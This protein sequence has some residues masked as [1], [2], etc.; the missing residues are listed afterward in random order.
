VT[1][2]SLRFT[3][4]RL[5]GDMPSTTT[6]YIC[7][8][9]T[10]S[11]SRSR[12]GHSDTTPPTKLQYEYGPLRAVIRNRHLNYFFE[13]EI[14]KRIYTAFRMN[15]YGSP[16]WMKPLQVAPQKRSGRTV[17]THIETINTGER[18][19]ISTVLRRV[20]QGVVRHVIRNCRASLSAT[21]GISIC[22]RR[23]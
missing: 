1:D 23:G 9:N 4:V 14:E 16:K 8:L 3:T 22:Q 11:E 2:P 10:R 19:E 18:R 6:Q 7:G 20:I 12:R 21:A 5:F 15:E 17:H 13:L